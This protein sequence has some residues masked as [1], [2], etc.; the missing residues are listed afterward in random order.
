MKERPP[1]GGRS[2]SNTLNRTSWLSPHL[3]EGPLQGGVSA[4]LCN[5]SV[6]TLTT[7]SYAYFGLNSTSSVKHTI[8]KNIKRNDSLSKEDHG[9]PN[10]APFREARRGRLGMRLSFMLAGILSR[11]ASVAFL[12]YYFGVVSRQRCG[13]GHKLLGAIDVDPEGLGGGRTVESTALPGTL[14][15]IG[16]GSGIIHLHVR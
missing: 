12:E 14:G 3:G 6:Y 11:N 15:V 2:L 8:I 9:Q 10:A 4:R 1:E 5:R 13:A 16:A 7:P